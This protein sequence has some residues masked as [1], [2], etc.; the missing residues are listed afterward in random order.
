MIFADVRL[1]GLEE[2][3]L[4]REVKLCWLLLPVILTSGAS[5][6]PRG[7]LPLGVGYIAKPWQPLD[8]M[9]AAKRR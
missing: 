1:G 9:I 6:R 3:G 7:E 8:V 2:V 4:P 5:A